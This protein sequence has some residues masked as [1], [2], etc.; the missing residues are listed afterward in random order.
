MKPSFQY[1][2]VIVAMEKWFGDKLVSLS[3]ERFSSVTQGDLFLA[4]GSAEGPP[5]FTGTP[6]SE[7]R[8]SPAIQSQQVFLSL[9]V[10]CLRI[11]PRSWVTSLIRASY[12]ILRAVIKVSGFMTVSSSGSQSLFL[13]IY[14]FPCGRAGSSLLHAGFL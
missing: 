8:P 1:D 7:P 12:L 13:K 14:L 9:L 10:T 2:V 3:E 6:S 11:E 5:G 4:G